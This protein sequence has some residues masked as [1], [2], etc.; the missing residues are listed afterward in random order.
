VAGVLT[1]VYDSVSGITR[2]TDLKMAEECVWVEISTSEGF[3]IYLSATTILR[4]TRLR[5]H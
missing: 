1:A 5:T 4:L 3:N 2:R